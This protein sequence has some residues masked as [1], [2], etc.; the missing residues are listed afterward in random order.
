MAPFKGMQGHLT[1]NF[2]LLGKKHVGMLYFQLQ[3]RCV[4]FPFQPNVLRKH[5]L[6]EFVSWASCGWLDIRSDGQHPIF[7]L[8]PRADGMGCGSRLNLGECRPREARR[9]RI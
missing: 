3:T 9:Q 8:F 6:V 1:R 5:I 4:H 2:S 7:L